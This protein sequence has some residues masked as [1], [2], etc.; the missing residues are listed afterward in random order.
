M[1][2]LGVVTNGVP[3][4]H[5]NPL[6]DRAV[7]LLLFAQ[8]FLDFERFL[9]RLF[10]FWERKRG[11]GWANENQY[12]RVELQNVTRE[13]Y[14][15]AFLPRFQRVHVEKYPT[16]KAIPL[17]ARDNA[18]NR[19]LTEAQIPRARRKIKPFSL[20]QRKKHDQNR[21]NQLS[22]QWVMFSVTRTSFLASLERIAWS[23]VF[24]VV[25]RKGKKKEE[26]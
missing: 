25:G 7:L 2:S 19:E 11:I 18:F 16:D 21:A 15:N 20:A 9:R 8:D 1:S 24:V 23:Y 4:L 22:K 6:R 13:R 5:A 3:G 14:A 12:M 26:R 10:F 17:W